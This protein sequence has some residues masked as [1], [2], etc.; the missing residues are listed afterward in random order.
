MDGGFLPFEPV[1]HT[2]DL[3]YIARGRT[4]EELFENAAR[5]LMSCYLDLATVEPREELPLRLEGEDEEECLIAW[6]QEMIYRVEV[7]RFLC[8][9]FVVRRVAPPDVEAVCRGE[10]LDP[11]RH[12]LLTE[13]K[14]ATYHDLRIETEETPSGRIYRTRIV[15]DL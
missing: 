11:S 15:L 2:A 3:A 5:A 14:A 1:D 13:L 10:R 6:L 9:E 12:A 8:C 4:R 7:H